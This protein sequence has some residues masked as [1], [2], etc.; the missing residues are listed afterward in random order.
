MVAEESKDVRFRLEPA[1]DTGKVL[2][3]KQTKG[4]GMSRVWKLVECEES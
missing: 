1:I 2:L 3:M 4:H